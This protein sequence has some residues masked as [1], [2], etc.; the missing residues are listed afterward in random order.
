MSSLSRSQR[1]GGDGR[2]RAKT[3]NESALTAKVQDL[4]FDIMILRVHVISDKPFSWGRRKA[5]TLIE[6]L[7]VIAIIAILAAMILPALAKAKTKAQ[8]ISCLNNLKQMSLAFFSYNSDNQKIA[9][10]PGGFNASLGDWCTGWLDWN[11]GIPNGANTNTSYLADGALGPYTARSLGIYKCPADVI[12]SAAGP[13]VRSIS[14]NGFVGGTTE[15]TVYGLTTY[16]MFLRETDFIRP[17]M[18]WVF[19]DEHPDSINDALFG[20]HMPAANTWPRAASWDDVPAS[21]HNNACGFSFGDG[22][23]EIKKWLDSQTRVPIRK[24]SPA[25]GTGSGTGFTS[26]RDSAWMVERTSQPR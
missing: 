24:Q 12:P 9:P 23:G 8:G 1:W 3:F 26:P 15:S 2:H 7:V 14:M 11:T 17:S 6:L 25:Q 19:L 4:L 16:R 18:T 13:R 21:Y 10:N 20:M 5:F 22:H